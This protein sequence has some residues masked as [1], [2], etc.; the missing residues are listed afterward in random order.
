LI[1][2]VFVEESVGAYA[3]AD[4]EQSVEKLIDRDEEQQA[5]AAL[6]AGAG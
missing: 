2:D 3:D 5:V 4:E 6:A 1:G